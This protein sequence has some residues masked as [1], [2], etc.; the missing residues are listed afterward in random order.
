MTSRHYR[1]RLILDTASANKDSIDTA[2]QAWEKSSDILEKVAQTIRAEGRKIRGEIKGQSGDAMVAKF[3]AISDKLEL[4]AKA[5]STGSQALVVAAAAADAA[6]KT[7]EGLDA[8]SDTNHSPT[9]PEGPLPGAEPTLVQ[10]QALATYNS[11]VAQYEAQE[12]AAEEKARLALQH[13]DQQYAEATGMMKE[14]HGEPDPQDQ[15]P[16]GT[17][18]GPGGPGSPATPISPTGTP[19]STPVPGNGGGGDGPPRGGVSPT[20]DCGFGNPPTIT[21]THLDPPTPVGLPPTVSPDPGPSTTATP[22]PGGQQTL[23]G[24]I[25]NVV[26]QADSGSTFQ[27]TSTGSATS[28]AS[29]T[30]PGSGSVGGAAAGGMAG[31]GFGAAMKGGLAGSSPA[32]KAAS[33]RSIGAGGRAGAPGALSR[34]T[35]ASA[36]PRGQ[37]GASTAARSSAP[38]ATGS[39]SAAAG[40]TSRTAGAGGRAGAPGS[41][42]RGGAATGATSKRTGAGTGTGTGKSNGKSKGLFRRGANGST[43]G[44]R[45]A[46][47]AKDESATSAESLVYEQD[48]L[49]DDSVAPSVLD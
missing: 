37:A 7:R 45:S 2:I 9:K 49:G 46:S 30:T 40:S 4:D 8:S 33:V 36:T 15:A 42:A 12:A 21:T 43:T 13:L 5:M 44:G 24:P 11:N 47:K 32:L 28:V 41:T 29:A 1:D 19:G 6:I 20:P 26:G 10:T 39:R 14:V 27:A 34:S 16:P 31:A 17:P 3:A 23:G 25:T 22:N 35:S 18:S 38:G 48:W